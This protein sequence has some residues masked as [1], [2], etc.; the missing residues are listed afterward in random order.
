MRPTEA[1]SALKL[2]F[3]EGE[4]ADLGV[5]STCT[6]HAESFR[7]SPSDRKVV[8]TWYDARAESQDVEEIRKL[9]SD[10]LAANLPN[11][12]MV[13]RIDAAAFW[14]TARPD[15]GTLYVVRDQAFFR[16]DSAPMGSTRRKRGS[17]GIQPR[18][19]AWRVSRE[20]AR[21]VLRRLENPVFSQY[22]ESP[23][24]QERLVA[25]ALATARGNGPWRVEVYTNQQLAG[26]PVLARGEE[27]L[28][29]NAKSASRLPSEMVSIRWDSCL[30][31]AEDARWTFN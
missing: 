11:M 9:K 20:L 18:V 30:N 5:Y 26:R 1:E 25:R 10:L 22:S 14:D 15:E 4:E 27:L 24:P 19:P 21:S 31:L 16:I 17:P 3:K 23:A 12:S 2:R 7:H 28:E 6:F 13:S 29:Y 8:L